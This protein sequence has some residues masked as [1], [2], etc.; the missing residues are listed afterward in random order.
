[1]PTHSLQ[2]EITNGKD[3]EG[4]SAQA[5]T[6]AHLRGMQDHGAKERVGAP[7]AAAGRAR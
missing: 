2:G 3:S 7:G 1:L 4:A 6:A 5:G